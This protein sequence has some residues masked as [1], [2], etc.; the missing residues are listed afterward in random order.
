MTPILGK[1][2]KDY[3]RLAQKLLRKS[4][5]SYVQDLI[6]CDKSN[7]KFWTYVK[8][9]RKEKIRYFRFN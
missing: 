3:K 5:D 4:H 8:S 7:K 1:K 9:Q 6:T 2:Y